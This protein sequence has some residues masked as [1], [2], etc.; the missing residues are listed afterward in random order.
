MSVCKPYE[1]RIV[2]FFY[3]ELDAEERVGVEAHLQTCRRCREALRTLQLM[4]EKI[5]RQSVAQPDEAILQRMRNL[6]AQKIKAQHREKRQR[7]IRHFPLFSPAPF[8]QAG[9]AVL[10]LAVGFLLGRQSAPVENAGQS[11]LNNILTAD[12]LVR[13]ENGKI[14]PLFAGVECVKYN[15]KTGDVEIYYTTVND[16]QLTGSLQDATVRQMLIHAMLEKENPAVRLH[17]VKAINRFTRAGGILSSDLIRSLTLLLEK[18]KNLGIRLQVLRL[19]KNIPTTRAIKDVLIRILLNDPEPA[20]R[21]QAFE[22]LTAQKPAV[23]DLGEILATVNQD[24]SGYFKYQLKRILAIKKTAAEK[25]KDQ[26]QKV[27]IMRKEKP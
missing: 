19:L 13:T 16:I 3:D 24:S 1:K 14:D 25:S 18:E 23:P 2:L 8:F 10:L 17:A 5:P 9:L 21:I 15:R 11:A 27:K 22:N 20:M 4:G 6:L 26:T 7:K 12:R